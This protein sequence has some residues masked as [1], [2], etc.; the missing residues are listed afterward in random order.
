MFKC[1]FN[2]NKGVQLI[3]NGSCELVPRCCCMSMWQ[4]TAQSFCV[5]QLWWTICNNIMTI[6]FMLMT[7]T[8]S[9]RLL[10]WIICDCR[11]YAHVQLKWLYVGESDIWKWYFMNSWTRC[12]VVCIVVCLGTNVQMYIDIQMNSIFV[13]LFDIWCITFDSTWLAPQQLLLILLYFSNYNACIS[14]NW[15]CVLCLKLL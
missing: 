9:V 10:M 11:F 14:A 4:T 15:Y 6:L 1:K 8:A 2:L 5:Y 3:R 7:A 13:I 12:P